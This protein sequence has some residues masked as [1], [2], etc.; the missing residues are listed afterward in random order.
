MQAGVAR[1]VPALV[2]LASSGEGKSAIM[3]FAMALCLPIR[4][5]PARF[6]RSGAVLVLAAAILSLLMG[7]TP[8]GA[9]RLTVGYG[10]YNY[11][12]RTAGGREIK[13]DE[14][15]KDLLTKQKVRF[16]IETAPAYLGDTHFGASLFFVSEDL[17]EVRLLDFPVENESSK[18]RVQ[19][20]TLMPFLFYTLGNRS[21]GVN[22]ERL[23]ST[24]NADA[25]GA[26][27]RLGFGL[28]LNDTRVTI[29]TP[30]KTVV[31]RTIVPSLATIVFI[32][33]GS[34]SL[35]LQQIRSQRMKIDK[36]D[37]VEFGVDTDVNFIAL[38]IYF[39]FKFFFPLDKAIGC[40][41]AK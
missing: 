12:Y 27:I 11:T 35:S 40:E 30:N 13:P 29:A 16:G 7:C 26:A 2:P 23:K 39:C 4:P 19:T 6:R 3:S 8:G 25:G 17:D 33:L 15:S 36:L 18:V 21:L 32:D 20:N 31:Q 1:C 10:E 37:N 28:G 9:P 24:G 41:F 14:S 34:W 38:N 22:E 5:R